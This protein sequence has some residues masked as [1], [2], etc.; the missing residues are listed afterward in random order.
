MGL[1]S[2]TCTATIGRGYFST[3]WEG[4]PP[5]L[6]VFRCLASSSWWQQPGEPRIAEKLVLQS[7]SKD[8]SFVAVYSYMRDGLEIDHK[9]YYNI[10][11]ISIHPNQSE[12]AKVILTFN[13]IIH[14]QRKKKRQKSWQ[15]P[16]PESSFF[17]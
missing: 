4:Q 16:F 7:F 8:T 17:F 1:T 12:S 11:Y 15:I 9:M 10:E 6:Y 14:G 5:K 3:E 13:N 2:F